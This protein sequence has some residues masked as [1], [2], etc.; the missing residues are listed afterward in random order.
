M[1]EKLQ[2]AV[3]QAAKN[4]DRKPPADHPTAVGD[5]FVFPLKTDVTVSFLVV[6]F[7]PDDPTTA[8][9]V[10]L[11]DFP[12]SDVCDVKADGPTFA[13][14]G[15]SCWLETDK[16]PVANRVNYGLT[17]L[18]RECR[19]T[20]AKMVRGQLNGGGEYNED[21]LEHCEDVEDVL[22]QLNHQP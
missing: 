12:F 17:D 19:T 4:L 11:T 1:N 7:H 6:N 22:E 13:R 20:L 9:L 3:E 14:C 5:E 2:N 8:L 10:P 21:Y 15:L 18:A 16:T